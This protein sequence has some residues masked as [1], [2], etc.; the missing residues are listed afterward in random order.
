VGLEFAS[1]GTRQG[2]MIG[3]RHLQT[4]KVDSK[5]LVPAKNEKLK[6]R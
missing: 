4:E 5:E 3:L 6:N 1:V 2:F